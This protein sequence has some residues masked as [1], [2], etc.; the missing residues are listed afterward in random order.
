[1]TALRLD[2]LYKSSEKTYPPF[3]DSEKRTFTPGAGRQSQMS[4]AS[5][6]E[7][8]RSYLSTS[9]SQ[10]LYQSPKNIPIRRPDPQQAALVD[11]RVTISLRTSV[12]PESIQSSRSHYGVQQCPALMRAARPQSRPRSFPA[13]TLTIQSETSTRQPPP[14]PNTGL[15]TRTTRMIRSIED[16]F[17]C[18]C[19]LYTALTEYLANN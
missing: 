13:V 3:P 18:D 15:S 17:E 7:K 8:S 14:K 5:R 16:E 12:Q 11:T 9:P 1:M 2:N 19:K 6:R 10:D 4:L